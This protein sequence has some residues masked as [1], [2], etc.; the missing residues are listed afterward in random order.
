MNINLKYGNDIL[1]FNIPESSEILKISE[2]EFSVSEPEFKSTFSELLDSVSPDYSNI[3]LV[4]SDK[5]RLCD[6]P[7]YLPW[8]LNVL[9][10]KGVAK[11][12]ITIYI[13]YGTHPF[14][15][16]EESLKSYGEIFHT[17]K[18]VHHDCDDPSIF[19]NLGITRR[20]TPVFV[21]NDILESSLIITFGAISYHY[22]AGFGGGRKL[23]FPGLAAKKSIYH[24]HSL[25]LNFDE[26]KLA[27][28]CQPGNLNANPVAEDLKDVNDILPQTISIHGILNSKG[29]VCM[30]RL[31]KSYDDFV[32]ACNLHDNYF[33]SKSSQVFDMVV[34]SSGGYPKDINFIQAHKSIHHSAAFV[35][36]G[37]TLIILTE[38]RDG[39]GNEA[40]LPLFNENN[41]EKMFDKLSKSYKGNGG[42]ALA[43]KSKT[44]RINIFML[45]GLDEDTCSVMGA[46]KTS[47]P[48]IKTMINNHMGSIAVIENASMLIR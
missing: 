17:Y 9:E 34:A 8:V 20:G 25:F 27:E 15:S 36:D 32:E 23:L 31:G 29:K 33:K 19:R 37:G 1:V 6:Y 2:P 38:C 45:T 47:L 46:H 30:L 42:T 12:Q 35:K 11:I 26:K 41:W 21:R 43:M 28:G 40:F 10:K 22:F 7:Q 16:E 4:V 18:F 3:G 5:T 14:Q 13:A 24:N 44:S 48:E 39:I